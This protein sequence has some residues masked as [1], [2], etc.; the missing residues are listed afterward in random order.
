MTTYDLLA[1]YNLAVADHPVRFEGLDADHLRRLEAGG[2]CDSPAEHVKEL[3]KVLENWK[4]RIAE[5]DAALSDAEIDRIVKSGPNSPVALAYRM[6]TASFDTF[7]HCREVT[8]EAFVAWSFTDN[9]LLAD[10]EV[11]EVEEYEPVAECRLGNCDGYFHGEGVCEVALGRI[12]GATRDGD[13]N[14]T[15]NVSG[16]KPAELAVWEDMG[17]DIVRTT[18]P[19]EAIAMAE[20]F[21]AFA[22]GIR[23]GARMLNAAGTGRRSDYRRP[24]HRGVHR[25]PGLGTARDPRQAP[26]R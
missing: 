19:A 2:D 24:V 18:D 17:P 9:P 20:K 21:E 3:L 6:A 25:V 7:C 16:G 10:D 22:A 1:A 26:Q 13:L 8:H 5:V 15:V 14:V 11:P 12:E 23:K 4:A